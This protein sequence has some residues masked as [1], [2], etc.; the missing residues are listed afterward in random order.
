MRKKS[1]RVLE[2][3]GHRKLILRIACLPWGNR[4]YFGVGDP[5]FWSSVKRDSFDVVVEG[6]SKCFHNSLP[7]RASIENLVPVAAGLFT[8]RR[9]DLKFA[10]SKAVSW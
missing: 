9:Q 6:D 8:A 5:F 3:K 10:S 7:V 2:G 4:L 1:S